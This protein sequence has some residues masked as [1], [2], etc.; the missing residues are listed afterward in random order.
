MTCFYID[1]LYR[2]YSPNIIYCVT[3]IV[4]ITLLL[5]QKYNYNNHY[6][7]SRVYNEERV[8]N[9]PLPYRKG[10]Y[11][12]TLFEIHS[13][14]YRRDFA[15]PV[16]K[17]SP[18]YIGKQNSVPLRQLACPYI[19]EGFCVPL[20]KTSPIYKIHHIY[21]ASSLSSTK[22]TDFYLLLFSFADRKEVKLQL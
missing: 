3:F 9:A 12:Y 17:T 5:L 10:E 7:T 6:I 1:S 11:T 22:I 8:S 2:I 21:S 15:Y 13:C 16:R 19:Q 18:I 14:I 4:K 20:R